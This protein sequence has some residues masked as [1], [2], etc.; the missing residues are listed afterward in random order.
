MLIELSVLPTMLGKK[1]S[2]S[3]DGARFFLTATSST[4]WVVG[5]D[6]SGETIA[7]LA[8]ADG[9]RGEFTLLGPSVKDA[10]ESWLLLLA[11]M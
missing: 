2:Y 6:G 1:L 5:R 8:R 3:H 11:S 10:G 7:I 9:G 4:T